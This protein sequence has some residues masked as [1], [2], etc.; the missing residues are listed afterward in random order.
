MSIEL[1]LSRLAKPAQRALQNAG[2][3]SLEQLA[4]FSEAEIRAKYK[5]IVEFSELKDY[6]AYI[7][8]VFRCKTIRD[9]ENFVKAL[10]KI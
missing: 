2:I 6:D 3:T 4:G 1:L 10:I 8:K 5:E 7:T 9:I